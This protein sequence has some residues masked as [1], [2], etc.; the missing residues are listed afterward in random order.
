LIKTGSELN[1]CHLTIR[2][3]RP[4]YLAGLQTHK[5]QKN[6]KRTTTIYGLIMGTILVANMIYMTAMCYNNPGFKDTDVA[7]YAAMIIVFSMIFV[8]VKHIRDITYTEVFPI[9]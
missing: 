5:R 1:L 6:R 4:G 8:A 9:G 2:F 7:G 3:Y